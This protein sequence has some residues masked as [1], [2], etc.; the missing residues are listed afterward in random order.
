MSGHFDDF[1]PSPDSPQTGY[2]SVMVGPGRWFLMANDQFVFGMLW[3]NAADAV[4]LLAVETSD[5]SAVSA[6]NAMLD[7]NHAAGVAAADLF[8]ELLSDY[9]TENYGEG[10][11]ADLLAAF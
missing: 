11:L 4:G 5:D 3:T 6:V 2:S 7:A 8:D 9:P 10:D 1:A